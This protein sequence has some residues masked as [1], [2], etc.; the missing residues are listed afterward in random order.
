MNLIEMNVQLIFH[1]ISLFKFSTPKNSVGLLYSIALKSQS[2][3][4]NPAIKTSTSR[5]S[6]SKIK[7]KKE[8]QVKKKIIPSFV[9]QIVVI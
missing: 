4:A 1:P 7:R 3:Y 6:V 9:R 5:S 2:D 8:M